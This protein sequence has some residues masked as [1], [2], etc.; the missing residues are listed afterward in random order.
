[1]HDRSV[2]KASESLGFISLAWRLSFSSASRFILSFIWEYFFMT[3]ASLWRSI[4]VLAPRM[5]MV[6]LVPRRMSLQNVSQEISRPLRRVVA[7]PA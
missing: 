3:C 5:R 1:M 6:L 2:I 4:C 7:R